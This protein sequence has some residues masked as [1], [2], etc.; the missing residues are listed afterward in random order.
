MHNSSLIGKDL[1]DVS[2]CSEHPHFNH[3]EE[4]NMN[5]YVPEID[6]ND[7]TKIHNSSVNGKGSTIFCGYSKH[8]HFN[9]H[10]EENVNV[11]V[12]EIDNNDH[13]KCITVL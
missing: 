4:E 1:T 10:E 5:V 2:A 7:H 9:H 12:P 3:R 13:T 6:N 8:L 11:C